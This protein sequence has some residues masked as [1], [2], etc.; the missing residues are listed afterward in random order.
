MTSVVLLR[1]PEREIAKLSYELVYTSTRNMEMLSMEIEP[2]LPG[3]ETPTAS[4][5]AE[6]LC[7][8]RYEVEIDGL[9][10]MYV[11]VSRI[12]LVVFLGLIGEGCIAKH[13]ITSIIPY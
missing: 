6:N 4:P 8:K 5:S 3:K 10:Y 1:K 13:V 2:I 7:Y 12:C 9:D 11:K